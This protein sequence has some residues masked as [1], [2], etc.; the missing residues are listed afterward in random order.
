VSKE[1]LVDLIDQQPV[2]RETADAVQGPVREFLQQLGP[3]KDFLHGK[4]LGHPLHPALT[5]I[6]VGAWTTAL[7]LD[8]VEMLSG[9]QAIAGAADLA[10][11]IGLAGA[12]ASAVTGLTDWSETDG[13][14]KNV[15]ALH[16]ALN[17]AAVGIYTASLISR[18]GNSRRRGVAL[19]MIGYAIASFSA[20]LGGHLVFGEQAGVDHA[21]TSDQ[22]QPK[23]FTAV[24]RESELKERKPVRADVGDTA[25]LLVKIGAKIYALANTCTHLGGPLNEG[26]LEGDSIRCPWHGSRFCLT[27]GAVLGGPAVF[28]E[29]SFDVRVR[30]GQIEI[31]ARS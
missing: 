22:G 28:D 14:A 29:R 30:D 23:K 18:R 1:T 4:W 26:K 13:R 7:A 3:V 17:L 8:A 5:D 9:E 2:V 25:V 16:G 24:M 12:V 6:P 11:G 19:S 15:G 27:D 20:Y 21:A 31:R 10:I